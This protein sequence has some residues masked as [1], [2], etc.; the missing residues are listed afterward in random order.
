MEGLSALVDG[1]LGSDAGA[2][3][4]AQWRE[5]PQARAQWHA[6]ALIGDVMRSEDLASPVDRDCAFLARL[7]ARLADEPVV[8]APAELPAPVELPA[9]AAVA[10]GGSRRG[11][12]TPVA[13]AAGF[14]VV[15]GALVATSVPG[16]LPFGGSPATVAQS[17]AAS[18]V[19]MVPSPLR[20]VS[21]AQD[22]EPV[23]LNGQLIRDA[24]L[25]EYLSVHKKF[26]GSSA[27][28]VPSGFL[29]NAA[30][31]APAR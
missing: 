2:R 26:G 11:W 16:S 17:G 18:A 14:V 12:R 7:R 5:D 8:L 19:A 9:V 30:A 1:E 10:A 29:R 31:E 20:A 4:C 6:Y 21:V 22:T 15:A 3:A 25:D 23:R 24:R 28:G 13:V 27:P